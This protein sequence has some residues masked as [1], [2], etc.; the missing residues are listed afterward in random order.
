MVRINRKKNLVSEVRK[1]RL[2]M[3]GLAPRDLKKLNLK[4]AKLQGEILKELQAAGAIALFFSFAAF[5]VG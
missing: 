1:I 4:V 5:C 2:E 3:K